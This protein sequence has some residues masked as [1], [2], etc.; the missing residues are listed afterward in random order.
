[1]EMEIAVVENITRVK[2]RGRLDSHGV[3]QVEAK[4]TASVAASGRNALVDLS[5]LA[6]IASM[7]LRMF[8]GVKKAVARRGA[9]MILYAPQPQVNDVFATSSMGLIIPI[10]ENEAE[11]LDA[12]KP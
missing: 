7:G 10:V 11:A 6:F 12:L 1:M 2:L 4:F 5:E 8:I 9:K 3:D